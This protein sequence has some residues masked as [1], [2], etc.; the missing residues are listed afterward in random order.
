MAPGKETG[1]ESLSWDHPLKWLHCSFFSL[2]L[3]SMCLTV[4]TLGVA[5]CVLPSTVP[6]EKSCPVYWLF[7]QPSPHYDRWLFSSMLPASVTIAFRCLYSSSGASSEAQRPTLCT[8][9]E[10]QSRWR[11]GHGKYSQPS[12]IQ[13]SSNASPAVYWPCHSGHLNLVRVFVFFCLKR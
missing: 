7:I 1:Q 4:T 8:I 13:A 6:W 3:S 5:Q 9:Q 12:V 11:K 2:V 10:T